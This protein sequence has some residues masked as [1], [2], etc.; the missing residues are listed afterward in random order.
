MSG[1][2]FS[3]EAELQPGS[4]DFPFEF[5]LPGNCPSSFEGTVG[6]IRYEI[7]VVVDRAFKLDQEKKVAVR[8][9]APL[10]LNQ[11]PYSRVSYM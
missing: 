7:K 11:E 4:Y 8:I 10:D 3:G 9:I 2:N 5:Q 6:H 1:I